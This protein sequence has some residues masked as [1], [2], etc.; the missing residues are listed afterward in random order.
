MVARRVSLWSLLAGSLSILVCSVID[1]PVCRLVLAVATMAFPPALI[2][3]GA[4]RRG[5]LGRLLA[6]LLFF[7]FLL[8][9]CVIAMIVLSAGGDAGAGWLGL[10]PATAVMICGLWLLAL[11]LVSLLFAWDFDRFGPGEDDLRRLRRF[12]ERRTELRDG[13]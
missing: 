11:L 5:R 9:G 8:Q 2:A 7:A 6:P 10:P 13:D 3:L 12:A 4:L 1:H